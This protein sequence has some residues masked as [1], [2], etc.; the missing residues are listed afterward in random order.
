[1]ARKPRRKGD[2]AADEAVYGAIRRAMHLGRLAAGTKLQEPAL[3]R[4]LK[5]SRERVRKALHR[6]VHEGWLTAVP[7][8]GT[9]VPSLSVEEM[10]EIYD[11]R[12]MLEAAIV[13]RL[14]EGHSAASAKKLKAHIA[15]ERAALKIDDRGRL[16]ELSGDFHILLA[17]LCGNDEL[18]KLLRALLTRSTMHFSLAAPQQLH[19]CAGPHDHGDIAEAILTG[20]AEKASKLMLT[21]LV[22]LVELQS[23]RPPETKPGRLE[24]AFG[25]S[26]I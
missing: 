9:F 23:T 10:R 6:L 19:N 13:R 24:E 20:K 16:F 4:V 11:V 3:A 12:S 17:E 1:M 21:H 18:T 14:S 15:A 2:V 22:G 7:N 8:R 25:G 26:L 5:V